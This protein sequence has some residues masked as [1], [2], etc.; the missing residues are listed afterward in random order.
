MFTLNEE[1]DNEELLNTTEEEVVVE[2][3]VE[4]P[5][6]NPALSELYEALPKSLHGLV[7]PILNKWQ[8]GIDQQFEAIAPYR[9]FADSGIN[10]DI[11]EASLELATQ[12]STNPRAVFD[13]LADRYGWAQAQQIMQSAT[14]TAAAVEDEYDEE[15]VSDPTDAEL[16]ALKAEIESLKADRLSEQE[17]Q[18][19]EQYNFEIEASLKALKEDHGD[20]DEDII[21]KRAMLLSDDYPDAEIPQLIGAAFEQYQDELNRMRE[22]VKRAPRVAGGTGNSIPAPTPRKLESRE[23]RIAAIEEIAKKLLNQ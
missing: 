11:I 7:E 16:K 8:S 20:V 13:E 10:A 23:D 1:P 12:I 21:L 9:R 6:G 2:E 17:K 3:E 22:S 4:E 19:E 18:A 5:S 15:F 14:E